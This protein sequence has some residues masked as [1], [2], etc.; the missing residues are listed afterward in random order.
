MNHSDPSSVGK[1]TASGPSWWTYEQL[2]I[3]GPGLRDVRT[4]ALM[5][6]FVNDMLAGAIPHDAFISAS[7]LI[8]LEKPD[9]G[10]RHSSIGEAFSRRAREALGSRDTR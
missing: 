5:R 1:G 9:G 7:R 10:I 6:G 3:A 2:R 8:A 4:W